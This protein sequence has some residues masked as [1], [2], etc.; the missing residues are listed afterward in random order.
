MASNVHSGNV[1]AAR[2]S[3]TEIPLTA[4]VETERTVGAEVKEEKLV[5]DHPTVTE[6]APAAETTVP[7]KKRP[8]YCMFRVI[9]PV[10]KVESI[11]G[12]NG[13]LI[14]MCEETKANIRVLKGPVSDPNRI[15]EISSKEDIEAPLS[16]AMDAVIRVFKCVNEFPENES[17]GVASI[18]FCS[19]RLLLTSIQ[20]TSL[21]ETQGSLLKRIQEN[22]GCYI[23]ILSCDEVSKLSTNSDDRVVNLKGEG[24]KVLQALEAVLGHLCMFLVDHTILPLYEKTLRPGQVVLNTRHSKK[25]RRI[26]AAEAPH[27][28]GMVCSSLV[29]VPPELPQVQPATACVTVENKAEVPPELPQVQPATAFVTVENKAEVPPELPQVQPATACEPIETKT[30][31]LVSVDDSNMVEDQALTGPEPGEITEEPQAAVPLVPLSSKKSP[32][33]SAATVAQVEPQKKPIMCNSLVKVEVPPELPKVQPASVVAIETKRRMSVFE[34]EILGVLKMIA[35]NINNKPESPPKPTF[36]DCE[37]KLNE[38]G[39]AKDDPLHLVA[40]PIFCDEKENYRE[41]W[42]KLN[43]NLCVSWVRMIGRSKRFT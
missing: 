5:A 11:I 16:P 19:I 35:D 24:L 22:T 8:G 38:L 3:E 43:P 30:E 33:P 39:W 40:L 37:K 17:D 4:T 29:K 21:L 18:P 42:M 12:R 2:T 20:A 36:E 1:T 32:P 28:E 27:K 31:V 13:G 7:K 23:R 25:R 10:H 14:K 34:E 9:V 15:V 41:L 26:V 6:V